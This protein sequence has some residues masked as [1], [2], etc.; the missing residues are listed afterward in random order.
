MLTRTRP[1]AGALALIALLLAVAESAWAATCIC[2]PSMPGATDR[3]EMTGADTEIAGASI[4]MDGATAEPHDHCM[5]H[6]TV[7]SAPDDGSGETPTCPFAPMAAASCVA[8]SLPSHPALVEAS[9]P[10]D[11]VALPSVARLLEML[12]ERPLFHPPRA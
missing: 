5:G 9:S 11:A 8:V 12:I 10:E 4:D 3:M 1:L 6:M 2:M 7:G